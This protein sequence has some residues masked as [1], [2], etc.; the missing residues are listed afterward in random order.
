MQ[1]VEYRPTS[2]RHQ[3]QFASLALALWLALCV[4]L[5]P[6]P[7]SARE[8][9]PATADPVLEAH[10]MRISSELRCLVCQNETIAAS[11]ADLAVDLRNQVREMLRQGRSEAEIM[12]YMTDRYGDFVRYRPPVK[13]TTWVLWY[14]PAALL[15]GGVAA[16]VLVLR[17][18]SRMDASAFEHDREDDTRVAGGPAQPG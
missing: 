10:V 11:H 15:V 3:F 18:R 8:A 9:A 7:A 17:R 13:P 5:A 12:S 6:S 2:A 14:G 16:L 1:K 4:A